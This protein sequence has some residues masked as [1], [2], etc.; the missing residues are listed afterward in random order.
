[1]IFIIDVE[2]MF[3]TGIAKLERLEEEIPWLL[4]N[5]KGENLGRFDG[6]VAS[7]KNIVSPRFTQVTGLPP[8][9]GKKAFT[10]SVLLTLTVFSVISHLSL[11]AF[12]TQI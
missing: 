12:L 11:F 5:S 7:D 1:M 9:L 4:K 10:N 2:S 6:V 8:P 3:G